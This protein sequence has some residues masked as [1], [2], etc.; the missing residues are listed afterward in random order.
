MIFNKKK[1][2]YLDHASSTPISARAL[3]AYMAGEKSFANS[4]SIHKDGLFSK[5]LVED[6]KAKIAHVLRSRTDEIYF[7]SSGTESDNL[8][9][10]GVISKAKE[11]GMI[12]PHIVTTTIEHDAV[13]GVCKMMEKYG[14][15]V[16]YVPPNEEGFVD[17]KDIRDAIN[18]NTVLVSVMYVNNEVGTIQPIKEIAKSIRH[19]KK[20]NPSKNTSGSDTRHYP[21]FHT[22]A[23][24][25]TNYLSLD[26]PTLGVDLLSLNGAK[27]YAGKGSAILYVKKGTP[28]SPIIFSGKNT[29]LT[30]ATPAIGNIN[31]LAHA[32]EVS[33]KM[34][35]SESSR[36]LLLKK[37]IYESIASDESVNTRLIRT[38]RSENTLPCHVHFV[39]KGIV[40]ELVVLEL[41]ARNISVSSQSACRSEDDEDSYVVKSMGFPISEKDGTL[42]VTLGR[43]TTKADC[44][45][46]LKKIKEVILKYSL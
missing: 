21:L 25:A 2:I 15:S 3:K 26:V 28:I 42:R 7:I 11:S 41:D 8:A 4:H 23:C 30:P 5:S 29:N 1:R 12:N 24:Q 14:A 9:I 27:C 32:I 39:V 38:V 19:Y 45:T 31:A 36:L 6:A 13:L 37:Y 20:N 35:E 18:E 17:P 10:S 16:T 46:F 44:E 22:D 34:M 40:G 33:Q 43:S